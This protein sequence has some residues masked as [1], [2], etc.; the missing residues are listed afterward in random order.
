M[1]QQELATAWI[2]YAEECWWNPSR[3]K[4]PIRLSEHV[5]TILEVL[6]KAQAQGKTNRVWAEI[7]RVRSKYIT[8]ERFD[9]GVAQQKTAIAAL[10]M[11]NVPAAVEM[12]YD[13]RDNLSRGD[14]HHY[15]IATW[16]LGV[17]YWIHHA[18]N[19]NKAIDAWQE[20]I[21]GLDR[22]AWDVST[23]SDKMD[24]Y[25][26][27]RDTMSLVLDYAIEYGV[28]PPLE[29]FIDDLPS[30][31]K[32]VFIEDLE[33]GVKVS[34]EEEEKPEKPEFPLPIEN[35]FQLFVVYDEVPAGLPGPIGYQPTPRYPIGF[36]DVQTADYLEVTEVRIGEQD[37]RVQSLVRGR[38]SVNLISDQHHFVMRV[39]GE[40]MNKAGIDDGDLVV[41]RS[42]M[43]AENG[44]IVVA[45][46]SKV[47][48]SRATLKRYAL[49]AKT[50]TLSAESNDPDFEGKE[51]DFRPNMEN[52]QDGFYIRGIAV[53]VLKAVGRG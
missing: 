52:T 2:Q 13:S 15:A 44:D 53:A 41:I 12:F 47:D 39:R 24:W 40:S 9:A 3:I 5:E 17:I 31:R 30:R 20:A 48:V 50:I 32:L 16:M 7:E 34:G 43:S 49:R 46:I 22:L 35:F 28:L 51:W 25:Q 11:G 4:A 27:T 14:S 42:Q 38:R 10:E 29:E 18:E 8:M 6:G 19:Q 23:N 45:E 37:Y 21:D 36:H 26:E 33:E 1:N